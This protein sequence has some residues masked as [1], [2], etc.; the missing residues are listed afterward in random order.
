MGVELLHERRLLLSIENRRSPQCT[1]VGWRWL[2]ISASHRTTFRRCTQVSWRSSAHM[3]Q[4]MPDARG[5]IVGAGLLQ[6]YLK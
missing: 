5:C 3:I 2:Q 6:H 1:A 4:N